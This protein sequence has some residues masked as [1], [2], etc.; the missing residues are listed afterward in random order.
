RAVN[1][2]AALAVGA[3][4]A[5]VL[6]FDGSVSGWGANSSGQLGD[7]TPNNRFS[8]SP[9]GLVGATAVAAGDNHSM[10]LMYD[11]TIRAWGLNQQGQLGD[12]TRNNSFGPEEINPK[13]VYE[14]GNVDPTPNSKYNPAFVGFSAIAAGS[15]HS[16]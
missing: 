15:N 16:L 4:H 8:A 1:R 3:N 10:A 9:A 5:I 7:G 12:G 11:G 2:A 6:N 14:V 13:A